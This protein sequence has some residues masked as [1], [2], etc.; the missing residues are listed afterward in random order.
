MQPRGKPGVDA[1]AQA[2]SPATVQALTEESRASWRAGMRR[3]RAFPI[4]IRRFGQ[5][6]LDVARATDGW[7]IHR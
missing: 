6:V 5:A 3:S 2:A 7:L 4:R 1:K